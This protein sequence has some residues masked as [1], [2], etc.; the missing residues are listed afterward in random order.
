MIKV[1]F[2]LGG[3]E[4]N[5]G[6]GRATSI[7]A[8]RLACDEELEIHTVS[9]CETGK[10]RLYEIAPAI[11][12]HL[13]FRTS[14]S[15]TKAILTKRAVGRVR[16]L[17]RE[18]GIDILVACGALYYP[19]GI[20]AVRGTGA[21]CVC[22]EHTSPETEADYKFQAVCRK[23]AVRMADKLVTITDAAR[24]YYVDALGLPPEKGCLIYNPIPTQYYQSAAYCAEAQ[25]IISVGRLAY[26]KNFLRLVDIA[27]EVLKQHP[28]WS[29]DI[30]GEGEERAQLQD[31][32]DRLGLSQQLALKGQVPN[33]LE[34]YK[35]YAFL[36][37][38]SRYE[39]FPMSLLEAAANRLPMVSFDIKT[40][41]NEVIRDGENG[42][43]L[44]AEDTQG[45][46]ERI[47]ALIA[48]RDSRI[49]MSDCALETAGRFDIEQII[50]QW[51]ALFNELA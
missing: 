13:L 30:Y 32:I 47:N 2:L 5:G 35:D 41:P 23:L 46:V 21:K 24:Q 22:V 45:M 43:L 20:L 31:K 38:T 37:M 28:Q 25:K 6:I 19:L 39:G 40:G 27:N 16:K 12:E 9:Y 36:V 11:H 51:R 3:F 10:E 34:R 33:L 7:V 49:A 48:D 4:G 14:I 42:Y 29:W 26:P 15:M 1:C 17:L 44:H 18:H 8:N 50:C